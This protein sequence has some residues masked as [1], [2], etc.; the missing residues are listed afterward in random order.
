MD[1]PVSSLQDVPSSQRVCARPIAPQAFSS[2]AQET[3]S[4]L[5]CASHLYPHNSL[6][7]TCLATFKSPSGYAPAEEVLLQTLSHLWK[8]TEMMLFPTGPT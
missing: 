2:L 4:V 5:E 7:F 6:H 1:Q 8:T 3:P